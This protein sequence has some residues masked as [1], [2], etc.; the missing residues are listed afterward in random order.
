VSSRAHSTPW[1]T[2]TRFQIVPS[3]P[4]CTPNCQSFHPSTCL[5]PIVTCTE[6]ICSLPLRISFFLFF[7]LSAICLLVEAICL[8]SAKDRQKNLPAL[9]SLRFGNSGSYQLSIPCVIPTMVAIGTPLADVWLRTGGAPGLG[10]E[11]GVLPVAGGAGGRWMARKLVEI[12]GGAWA[13]K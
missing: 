13:G 7:I 3:S 10:A 5:L 12:L 8:R 2:T 11:P 6:P 9:V 4:S 1:V